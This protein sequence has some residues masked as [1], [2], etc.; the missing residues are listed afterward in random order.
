MFV[1]AFGYA[2]PANAGK[3][4][5]VRG[6]VRSSSSSRSSGSSSSSSS[7]SSDDDSVDWPSS[8]PTEVDLSSVSAEPVSYH[9]FP[10]REGAPGYIQRAP[11]REIEPSKT[12]NI[13]GTAS[14][15]GGYL[16]D[17]LYRAGFALDLNWRRLG[18]KSDLSFFVE[19]KFEDALY[20]GSSNAQFG[21]IMQP[22]MRWRVG[23]GAQ[24]MIDGR[25][26]GKG[27]REFAAGPNFTTDVDIFPFWPVILSGRFD[28]GTIY[29]ARSILTRGTLGLALQGFE[30]Y[31]GYEFRQIGRVALH[32]PTAGLRVWF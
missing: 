22:R 1:A 31:G 4:K 15:E 19:G 21:I 16:Y 32:G 6:E 28:Y 7:D 11:K 25:A 2:S 12:R 30:L 23:G 24:Y 14:A 29:K 9:L 20:L 5:S 3:L 17:S 8:E 18:L 10:Y 26:P 27:S 13:G